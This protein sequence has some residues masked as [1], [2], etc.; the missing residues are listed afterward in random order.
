MTTLQLPLHKKVYFA[1]DFHLGM[2]PYAESRRRE[3]A[4]VAWL[5]AIKQD[6]AAVFLLG[7]IF[8]FWFEYRRVVPKGFTRFLG[9]LCELS[10]A[11]VA[12]HFFAGNHD[13]WMW[14]Y[15]PQEIGAEVHPETF[16]TEINGVRF[17][18]AHGDGVG[19]V[20]RTYR[21][22][23]WLFRWRPAQV[24]WAALP[25][26][27]TV[28]F[29]LWWARRSAQKPPSKRRPIVCRTEPSFLF[30]E[31]YAEAHEVK[32]FVFGH[33][34]RVFDE[35][36]P[37]GARYINVG[38]GIKLYSYAV[39]DGEKLSLETFPAPPQEA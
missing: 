32:Y 16:E 18:M 20:G 6:A 10:D 26:R 34:H 9:K 33:L 25:S 1:S 35:P 24:M 5:D 12:I 37:G 36:L 3:Q 2:F 13:T 19:P 30:A 17:F 21:C 31:Q 23:R 14:D 8:D 27:I 29:G 7:D 4:I 22:M 39:F 28:G 15:L 11:G 38:D